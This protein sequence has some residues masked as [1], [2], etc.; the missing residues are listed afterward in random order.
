MKRPRIINANP[1]MMNNAGNDIR[2]LVAA[3]YVNNEPIRMI[4]SAK[5]FSA[6]AKPTGS[7][8]LLKSPNLKL[9]FR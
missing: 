3:L 6:I 1:G 2:G 7:S 5:N 9:Q 8:S 4:R